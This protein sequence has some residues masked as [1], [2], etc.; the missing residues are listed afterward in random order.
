MGSCCG[1]SKEAKAEA[2]ASG[3]FW[4]KVDSFCERLE[5]WPFLVLS[6]IG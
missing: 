6:A 2:K 5:S 3:G 4:S 1:A